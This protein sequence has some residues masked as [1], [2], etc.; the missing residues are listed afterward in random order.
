MNSE[1]FRK[2]AHA[3]IDESKSLYQTNSHVS[4]WTDNV[5]VIDYY[6]TIETRRVVSDVSPGYLRKLLPSGPPEEGEQ[7]E[8]IQEDI[9][10]KIMPGITHWYRQTKCSG[11]LG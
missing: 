4:T 10:S 2:A 6:D 3:S 9:E 5:S 8:A 1:E 11:D 7:W